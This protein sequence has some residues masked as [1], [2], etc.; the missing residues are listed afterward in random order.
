MTRS[1]TAHNPPSFQT[2]SYQQA[3]S[4]SSHNLNT[5]GVRAGANDFGSH[6]T[7]NTNPN[8]LYGSNAGYGN[9]T[10]YSNTGGSSYSGGYNGGGSYGTGNAT[11]AVPI[12]RPSA[13][14][15]RAM[16]TSNSASSRGID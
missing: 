9:N 12:H 3:S 16:I 2:S 1:N 8:N 15:L 14:D 7:S 5:Y 13:S 11:P 10:A 6:N 4:T